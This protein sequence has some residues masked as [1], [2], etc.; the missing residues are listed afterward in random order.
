MLAGN[1]REIRELFRVMILLN[2]FIKL[3]DNRIMMDTKRHKVRAELRIYIG[4]LKR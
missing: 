2:I 4:K 3:F 1:F